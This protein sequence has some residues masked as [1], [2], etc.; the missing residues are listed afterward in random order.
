MQRPVRPH[1][2][3]GGKIRIAERLV[4]RHDYLPMPLIKELFQCYH[5]V[6]VRVVER[7][8]EINE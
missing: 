5:T 4:G 6:A 7:V 1:V 8:V 3:V 2:N